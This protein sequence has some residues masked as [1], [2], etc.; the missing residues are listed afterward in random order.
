LKVTRARSVVD[1]TIELLAEDL[2]TGAYWL[3]LR[4]SQDPKRSFGVAP[5]AVWRAF[6]ATLPFDGGGRASAA[7]PIHEIAADFIRANA[8]ANFYQDTREP[9]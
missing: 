4:Q 3:D 8:A 6:R 7:Q 2:L 9:E 1:D 5:T